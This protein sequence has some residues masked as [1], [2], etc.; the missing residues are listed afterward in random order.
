MMKSN[1]EN[2]K[3]LKLSIQSALLGAITE[4]MR[5]IAVDISEN[6]IIL[7]FFIN[8]EITEDDKENISII[9]TEVIAD[10][11]DKFDIESVIKRVDYPESIILER[12][13][14]VFQRKER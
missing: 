1:Y 6:K 8:G 10:F 9:E 5:N 11:E 12:G 7:Y 13:C 3:R 14:S 4:N 2:I